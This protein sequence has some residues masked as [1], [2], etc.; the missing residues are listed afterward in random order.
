LAEYSLVGFV[1]YLQKYR[2]KVADLNRIVLQ[3]LFCQLFEFSKKASRLALFD[4]ESAFDDSE[5]YRAIDL[6]DFHLA[7]VT[8][9]KFQLFLEVLCFFVPL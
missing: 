5:V 4:S 1:V 3:P 7:K 6:F 8:G 9:G 2:D